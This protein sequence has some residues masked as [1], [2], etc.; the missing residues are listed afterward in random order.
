MHEYTHINFTEICVRSL[1]SYMY[2]YEYVLIRALDLFLIGIN[3]V[4]FARQVKFAT[5]FGMWPSGKRCG[6]HV[7]WLANPDLASAA[8]LVRQHF[9]AFVVIC[10]LEFCSDVLPGCTRGGTRAQEQIRSK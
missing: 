10:C 3:P 7:S 5:V 6:R 8:F 2:E 1:Y 9:F 4:S